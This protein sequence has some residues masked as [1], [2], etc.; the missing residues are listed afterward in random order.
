MTEQ[1]EI[2][3]VIEDGA[4]YATY[5]KDD[6]VKAIIEDLEKLAQNLALNYSMRDNDQRRRMEEQMIMCSGFINY[7]DG[8]VNAGEFAE[9][10]LEMIK[11]GE[12]DTYNVGV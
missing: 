10:Q 8:M 12:T 9:A 11:N 7:M 1:Q 6:T 4:T 5:L 3:K 2:D